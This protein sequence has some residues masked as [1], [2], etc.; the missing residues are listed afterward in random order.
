MI[1]FY[2]FNPNYMRLFLM[3]RHSSVDDPFILNRIYFIYVH[4]RKKYNN[5]LPEKGGFEIKFSPL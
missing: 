2:V 5:D 1:L 4:L 3:D